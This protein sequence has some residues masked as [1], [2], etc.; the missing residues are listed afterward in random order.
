MCGRDAGV[1]EYIE[2]SSEAHSYWNNVRSLA[3]AQIEEY[4]RRAFNSLTISFGCTGGQHRSVYFAE[5]LAAHIRHEYPQVNVRLAHREEKTWP[6]D[7]ETHEPAEDADRPLKRDRRSGERTSPEEL[8]D[9][10]RRGHAAS[11]PESR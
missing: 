11:A 5:R 6:R 3:N 7:T 10:G 9:G 2:R 4:L 8:I 1:V